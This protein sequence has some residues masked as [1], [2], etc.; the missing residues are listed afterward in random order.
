M[1]IRQLFSG[2]FKMTINKKQTKD[3]YL[4]KR[5]C[6]HEAGHALVLWDVFSVI[7][8]NLVSTTIH[9][10]NTD[11]N[12]TGFASLGDYGNIDAPDDA[13][14]LMSVFYA[15]KVAVKTAIKYGLLEKDF[16]I[17]NEPGFL[18]FSKKDFS[19]FNILKPSTDY[20][21]IEF[22]AK[23]HEIKYYTETTYENLKI[24]A[25]NISEKS[26]NNN[27]E[28][29]KDISNHLYNNQHLNRNDLR[30]I[31]LNKYSPTKFY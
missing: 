24:E 12:V 5:T 11:W 3:Y 20:E 22:L 30:D 15:G 13:K 31:I 8:P 17:E 6:I 14:K 28:C 10:E 25:E 2:M 21:Y 7:C 18:G 19:N 1:I 9:D 27:W 16:I 29:V 26:I 23:K 4:K